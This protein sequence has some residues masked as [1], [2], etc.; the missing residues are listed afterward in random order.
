M[1]PRQFTPGICGLTLTLQRTGCGQVRRRAT[2]M[3]A[4]TFIAVL[5]LLL[6]LTVR[7]APLT[8]QAQQRSRVPRTSDLAQ[9][10]KLAARD[11]LPAIY[12]RREYNPRCRQTR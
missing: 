4:T 10:A 9:L 7:V 12:N 8:A 3:H 2:P 6:A 11:R 5:I 1:R